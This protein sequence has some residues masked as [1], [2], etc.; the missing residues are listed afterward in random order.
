MR[1]THVV[2][3]FGKKKRAEERRSGGEMDGGEGIGKGEVGGERVSLLVSKDS[4]NGDMGRK[5]RRAD[6]KGGVRDAIPEAEV[7][8]AEA[9][10]AESESEWEDVISRRGSLVGSSY[11]G[12]HKDDGLKSSFSGKVFI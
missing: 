8:Q 2:Q 12:E 5:A 7:S 3:K 10:A 4:I 1:L 11:G 9:G 6:K